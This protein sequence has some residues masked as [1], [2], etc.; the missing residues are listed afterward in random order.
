MACDFGV[1]A[2]LAHDGD[3]WTD[4]G[5][6]IF[7]SKYVILGG[8]EAVSS[9]APAMRKALIDYYHPNASIESGKLTIGEGGSRSGYGAAVRRAVE[10][11]KALEAASSSQPGS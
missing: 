1:K 2:R 9:V 5:D 7:D 3:G 10:L 4:T 8:D 11:A 6:A